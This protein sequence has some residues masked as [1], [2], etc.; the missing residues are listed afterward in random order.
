MLRRLGEAWRVSICI[1]KIFYQQIL[2]KVMLL[3]W[4]LSKA[5]GFVKQ[6][7]LHFQKI[8]CVLLRRSCHSDALKSMKDL[9]SLCCMT[10]LAFTAVA[11]I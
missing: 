8:Y 9:L 11:C 7:L 2:I 3:K 10:V 1:Y 6:C 4:I 5:V